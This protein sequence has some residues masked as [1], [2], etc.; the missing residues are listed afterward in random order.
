[1]RIVELVEAL[2]LR[3][4]D[5]RRRTDVDVRPVPL[6]PVADRKDVDAAEVSIG[7]S[8]P[9]ALRLVLTEVANGGFGPGYGLLGVGLTG[10][11]IDIADS[12]LNLPDFY[13]VQLEEDPE[14]KRD[15]LVIAD[16]GCV[17]WE[18]VSLT[19]G[20]VSTFRGDTGTFEE[21][22]FE[23]TGMDVETWLLRWARALQAG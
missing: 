7:H 17:I 13:R 9:P 3:L 6:L 12:S 20:E 10:H 14:W 1:M 19:T 21:Q 4:V 2:R 18:T 22:H 23:P 16:Y 11:R 8:L 5:P 15:Q